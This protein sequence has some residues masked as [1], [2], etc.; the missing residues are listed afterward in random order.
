MKRKIFVDKKNREIQIEFC[1]LE[2]ISSHNGKRI[3]AIQF[4][5]RDE[6]PI[7]FHMEVDSNYQ[8]NGIAYEMMKVAVEYYGDDFGKPSFSGVGGRNANCED[9]YSQEG[10]SFIWHC[11]NTGLLKDTNS[12]ENPFDD[13]F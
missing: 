11:I 7:L 2:V 6:G 13:E 4:D 9:Y 12:D 1:D 3:G 8:R 5:D 10:S